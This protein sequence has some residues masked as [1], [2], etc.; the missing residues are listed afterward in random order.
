MVRYSNLAYFTQEA[1][2]TLRQNRRLHAIAIIIIGAAVMMLTLFLL[3]VL[4]T[5]MMLQELGAKA[6]IIVFLTDDIQPA[7]R[8]AILAQLRVFSG[9][10]PVHYV[11][12]EQAWHDFT[13]WFHEGKQLLPGL[14]QNPLPASYIMPLAPQTHSDTAA[15]TLVQRL[16]RLPGVEG[17]EYGAGWR[18][19]FQTVV[20]VLQIFSLA[21]GCL[22]SLGIIFIVANTIRLTI[23]TRLREIEIMQLVGATAHFIKGPFVIIGMLQGLLGALVALGVSFG[24]YH[25][26]L[27]QLSQTLSDVFGLGQLRFLPWPLI[28]GVLAGNIVLGYVGSAFSLRRMLRALP[29]AF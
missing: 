15:Q 4:N 18:R 2:L 25:T 14:Q 13:S 26:L 6:K 8:R 12:K 22:L 21:C 27:Y 9:P 11:S 23:Y 29:L 16:S 3:V 24:L 1:M 28:A 20:Q 10:H 19:A 7:Q 5:K 17:I